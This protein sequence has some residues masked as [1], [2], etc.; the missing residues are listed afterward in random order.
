MMRTFYFVLALLLTLKPL[1]CFGSNSHSLEVNYK[2]YDWNKVYTDYMVNWSFEKH[3]V[4]SP[5]E[6]K[7][8]PLES[9]KK[10]AD[11]VTQKSFPS[12]LAVRVSVPISNETS[13]S[14]NQTVEKATKAITVFFPFNKAVLVPDQK[15]HLIKEVEE[16]KNAHPN[17]LIKAEITASTCPLG[18]SAYNKNLSKKRAKT[19]SKLLKELGVTRISMKALGEIKESEVFCLNRKAVVILQAGE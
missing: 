2:D 17:S 6:S 13:L 4:I 11:N 7:K 3:F 15:K 8:Y 14:S 19:V 10:P 18:S 5:E 1:V 16:F 9:V 12:F